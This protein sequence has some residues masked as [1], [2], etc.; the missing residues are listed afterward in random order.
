LIASERLMGMIL[1]IISV[2]MM[3]DALKA[4]NA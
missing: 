3:L 4:F 2:Q 1:V